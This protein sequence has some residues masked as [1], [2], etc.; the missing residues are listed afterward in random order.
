MDPSVVGSP[1]FGIIWRKK[2][3]GTYNG[4]NGKSSKFGLAGSV[5]KYSLS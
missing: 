5:N 1:Q 2:L 4:W 3:M